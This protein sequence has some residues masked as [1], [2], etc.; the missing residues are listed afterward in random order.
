MRPFPSLSYTSCAVLHPIHQPRVEGARSH[1]YPPSSRLAWIFIYVSPVASTITRTPRFRFRLELFPPR[2]IRWKLSARFSGGPYR[3]LFCSSFSFF[4]RL[5]NG[6]AYYNGCSASVVP[7]RTILALLFRRDRLIHP[8]L[9]RAL[10]V[11]NG[12]RWGSY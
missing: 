5:F 3:P 4:V 2:K 11:K 9:V 12:E 1:L 6:V 8:A 10:A 7:R